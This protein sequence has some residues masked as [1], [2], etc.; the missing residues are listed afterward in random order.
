MPSTSTPIPSAPE[1]TS[2]PAPTPNGGGG[3]LAQTGGSGSTGPIAIGAAAFLAG[4][5]VIVVATGRRR[6]IRS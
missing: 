4:G 6:A 1:S 3:D 2:T 5:A